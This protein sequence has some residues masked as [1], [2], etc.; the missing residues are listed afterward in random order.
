MLCNRPISNP[1]SIDVEFQACFT[2]LPHEGQK[3]ASGERGAPQLGQLAGG[4]GVGVGARKPMIVL[5]HGCGIG[6]DVGRS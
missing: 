4:A 1:K 3:V 6:P 2:L 5:A